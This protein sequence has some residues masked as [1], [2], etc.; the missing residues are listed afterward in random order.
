MRDINY[1]SLHPFPLFT[2]I[3][4]YLTLQQFHSFSSNLNRLAHFLLQSCPF[5]LFT[6]NYVKLT[7]Y[8]KH[9]SI[10]LHLV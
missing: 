7:N 5:T 2:L 6:H 9:I 4:P 3:Y 1:F 10:S 8:V